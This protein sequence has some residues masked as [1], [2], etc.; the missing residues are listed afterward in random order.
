MNKQKVKK[1]PKSKRNRR[2]AQKRLVRNLIAAEK[3]SKTRKPQWIKMAKEKERDF[4][5]ERMK[6]VPNNGVHPYEHTLKEFDWV[7]MLTLKLYADSYTKDDRGGL[8]RRNR[9]NFV[10]SFMNNLNSK[11]LHLKSSDFNWVACEEFGI[12]GVG[13]VHIL[14]SFDHL[15]AKGREDKIPKFDFSEEKGLFFEKV[16]ESANFAMGKLAKNK[17]NGCLDWKPTW[18]NEGLVDYFCEFEDGREEKRFKSSDY[19]PIHK[20][21]NLE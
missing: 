14:F 21:I 1:T 12:S 8:G 15:K 4:S 7:G 5:F 17:S 18:E 11:W 20:K 19:W 6:Y 9:F 16:L 2:L 3:S 13:H 10:K